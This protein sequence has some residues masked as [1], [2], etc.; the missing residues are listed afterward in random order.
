MVWNDCGTACEPTCGEQPPFCIE[1]CIAK[2]VCI[3][4][5]ILDSNS[6]CILPT[7]CPPAV[8]N[9]TCTKP[10]TEFTECGKACEPSCANPHPRKCPMVCIPGCK[11]KAGYLR[12]VNGNCILPKKCPRK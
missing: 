8:P 3:E 4:G 12:D 10:N 9:T 2:C 11:C 7:E 6:N 1:M 5:F